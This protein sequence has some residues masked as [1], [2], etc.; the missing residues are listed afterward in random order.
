MP[1]AG[2]ACTAWPQALLPLRAAALIALLAMVAVWL[3]SACASGSAPAYA[4]PEAL[5]STE[6]L[7]E[8]LDDPD[9]RILDGRAMW[10]PGEA[11]YQEGHIPGAVYVDVLN[12]LSDPDGAVP[13]LIPPP[14]AFEAL[15]ER[16]GVDND[17]TVVV[18]DDEGG[19]WMARLWWA[20]RYYGHEDVKLLN[21]GLTSWTLA[22]LPLE[23]GSN[24]P[25]PVSFA[26]HANPEL[27]ATLDDVQQAIADPGVAVIDARSTVEY[28]SGHVPTAVNVPAPANLDPASHQLLP[29]DD[30]ELLWSGAG[31]DPAQPAITSCGGGYYAALDLFALSQLGNEQASLYDGSWLEWESDADL[32]VETG[33]GQTP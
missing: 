22:G 26:A 2:P 33:P 9:V 14:A 13:A 7:S 31:L 4:H 6:W 18:Y 28:R 16:L 29:A 8:H 25:A 23:E 32:P 3:L 11:A 17:T 24:V 21:G 20:L 1:V 15:M 19:A 30:L 10:G 5:A 12:D 27:L